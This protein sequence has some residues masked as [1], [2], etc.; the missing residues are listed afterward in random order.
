[1]QVHEVQ[2]YNGFHSLM[3]DD[4]GFEMID[5]GS[6]SFR[7]PGCSTLS[8]FTTHVRIVKEDGGG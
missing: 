3:S 6:G 2:C 7:G 4:N 1:M 8:T 5:C